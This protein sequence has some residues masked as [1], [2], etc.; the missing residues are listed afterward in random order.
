MA[1]WV[2]LLSFGTAILAQPAATEPKRILFIIDC[3]ASMKPVESAVSEALFDLVYSGVRGHMTNGDTYGIWLV[4]EQNDTSFK[5]EIWK[6]KYAVESA[7]RAVKHVKERGFKG[8][9]RLSEAFADAAVVIKNVEDLHIILI[10]NGETPLRGTPFDDI[11]NLR[12]REMAPYMKRAKATLNTTFVAQEGQIVA[13]AANSP[14]F[15]IEVPYVAPR[16]PKAKVAP[17]TTNIPAAT[18][19]SAPVATSQAMPK[20]RVASNPIIITKETVAQD[21]RSFHAMTSTAGMDSAPADSTNSASPPALPLPTNS[22]SLAST[23][24][25]VKPGTN[26]LVATTTTAT[27]NSAAT[28]SDPTSTPSKT[29]VSSESPATPALP[30]E[31]Q[32]TPRSWFPILWACIGATI[33]VLCVIGG[34]LMARSKRHEPSL[35][36]RS[37]AHDRV[38]TT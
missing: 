37:I 20:P 11:I 8:K 18:I 32:L 2:V 24:G 22:I 10:S 5:M 15:L 1:L 34:F 6:H 14:E 28:D 31:S 23:S 27:N 36:S 19:A 33:A 9:A 16:P 3:S 29:E 38:G 4:N 13:W 21:K 17:A 25:I 12:F 7:A 30:V 26:D 35:I